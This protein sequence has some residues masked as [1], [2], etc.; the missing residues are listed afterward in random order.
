MIGLQQSVS[1]TPVADCILAATGTGFNFDW[2]LGGTKPSATHGTTQCGVVELVDG[3]IL[4]SLLI[5]ILDDHQRAVYILKA[6]GSKTLKDADT[7]NI[8]DLVLHVYNDPETAN[9]V[10]DKADFTIPESGTYPPVREYRIK[11]QP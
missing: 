7:I 8:E 4:F 6:L 9:P 11:V 3:K 5:Y 10:T 1:Y 2:T